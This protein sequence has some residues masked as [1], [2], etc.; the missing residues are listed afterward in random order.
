MAPKKDKDVAEI[1]KEL[2]LDSPELSDLGNIPHFMEVEL[3]AVRRQQWRN[4]FVQSQKN[5]IIEQACGNKAGRDAFAKEMRT[6]AQHI[7]EI[8]A[9]CPEAKEKMIEIDQAQEVK[10]L[11]SRKPKA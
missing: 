10:Y 9:L 7:L 8:D 4:S 5:M 3:F 2:D 11:E 6:A 1:E